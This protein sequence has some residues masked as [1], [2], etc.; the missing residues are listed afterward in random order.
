VMMNIF[1][2]ADA[3]TVTAV[4]WLTGPAFNQPADTLDGTVVRFSLRY[5]F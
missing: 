1:N 2:F 5:T 4:N 3:R